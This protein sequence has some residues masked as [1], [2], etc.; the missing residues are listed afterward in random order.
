M[1]P[2]NLIKSALRA[3]NALGVDGTPTSDQHQDA[4][5]ILNLMLDSWSAEELLP[6]DYVQENFDL[7]AGKT[8]YTIG[9]A[10]TAA[11]ADGICASQTPNAGGSQ[12][13]TLNG[14]LAES[15]SVSMDVPRHVVIA[16]AG[17]DSGRTFTITGTNTYGDSITEEITG[18]NTTTVYGTKQ[19]KTVTTVNVDDDTAGAITVGTDSVV[20]TRRPLMVVSA[21]VRDSSG[22]D[23]PVYPSSREKYNTQTDKDATTTSGSEIT[24]L[25]YDRTYPTGEIYIYKVPSASGFTM[26]IDMWQPFQQI[27]SDDIDTALNLPGEYIL[28]LRWNLAAE[29]APEYGKEVREFVFLR[30]E[31]TME[32]VRKINARQPKPTILQ[33]PLSS[34]EGQ[35]A[36]NRN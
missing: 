13:L 10:T 19:F 35:A 17:D 32:A 11:D 26:Y 9:N 23:Y 29:L 33:P 1:T 6:F 30:A 36:V 8:N 31:S 24:Q 21:F 22:N 4:L 14:A 15:G 25:Y 3:I 28:A 20:D 2:R 16:S 18:P 12:D 5:E 27:G 7:T 34:V